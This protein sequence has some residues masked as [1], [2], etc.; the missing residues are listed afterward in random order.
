MRLKKI[1]VN[2]NINSQGIILGRVNEDAKY[3]IFYRLPPKRM[4]KFLNRKG[5]RIMFR[6]NLLVKE[7]DLPPI[8]EIGKFYSTDDITTSALVGFRGDELDG[9]QVKFM[10]YNQIIKGKKVHA[11]K[12]L[13]DAKLEHYLFSSKCLF[14]YMDLEPCADCLKS[15]V[16]T[17]AKEIVYQT[18]HKDKWNTDEYFKLV[19][20]NAKKGIHYLY[21]G[22]VL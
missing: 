4:T 2:K 1:L 9:I 8:L 10:S 18:K 21:I 3:A 7:D 22:S 16:K 13:T 12:I 19:Q 17:G 11:E 5:Y 15:I 14:W 20:E 6:V